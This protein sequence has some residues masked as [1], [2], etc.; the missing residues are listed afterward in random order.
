MPDSVFINSGVPTNNPSM[1]LVRA[2]GYKAWI[3]IYR[4]KSDGSVRTLY[5]AATEDVSLTAWSGAELLGLVT[6]WETHGRDW[7]RQEPDALTDIIDEEE[8]DEE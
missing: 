5:F 3:R 7:C 1:L 8:V 6:L 2:K 4:K